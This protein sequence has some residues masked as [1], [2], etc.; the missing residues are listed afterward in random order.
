VVAGGPDTT[1]QNQMQSV[2]AVRGQFAPAQYFTM[3]DDEKLAAPSFEE[4]DAGIAIGSAGM[5]FDEVVP[6]SLEYEAIV[7]DTLPQ[8]AGQGTRYVLAPGL[9]MAQTKSGAVA[10]AAIRR[11]GQARFRQA[12]APPAATLSTLR[13][14][15]MPL[16]EGAA[17]SVDPNV[18]TWSEY[19]AALDT[20]NRG[21]ARCRRTSL[22]RNTR[23]S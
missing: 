23:Y 4:M 22:P 2:A 16:T 15:I 8:P 21:A 13:W 11:A 12:D 18:R 20:L 5:S 7:I 14:T 3:S 17:A 1:L 10:R 19:R 9:L 6:A